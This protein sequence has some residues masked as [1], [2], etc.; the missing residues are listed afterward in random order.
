MST[1]EHTNFE[2]FIERHAKVEH[3]DLGVGD[4]ILVPM[5]RNRSESANCSDEIFRVEDGL[6]LKDYVQIS[7]K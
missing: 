2:K 1:T 6:S 4:L 3:G 7:K 5:R